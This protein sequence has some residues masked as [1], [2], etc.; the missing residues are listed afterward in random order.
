MGWIVDRILVLL[1]TL[2]ILFIAAAIFS[3]WWDRFTDP[4][5]YRSM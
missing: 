2:I 4:T 3:D 1:F 5:F